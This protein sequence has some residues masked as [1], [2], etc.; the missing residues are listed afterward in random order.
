MKYNLHNI[1]IILQQNTEFE[2]ESI[3]DA[4]DMHRI[5]LDCYIGTYSELN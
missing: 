5:R 3:K 1:R 4:A 2:K